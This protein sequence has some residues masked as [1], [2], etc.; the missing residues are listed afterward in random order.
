MSDF[1]RTIFTAVQTAVKNVYD[2]DV[3]EKMLVVETPKDPKMGDYSTSVAM[4]LARV[5]HKSPMEM[6]RCLL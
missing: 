5:L 4:R 2:V 1:T 3:D 6:R